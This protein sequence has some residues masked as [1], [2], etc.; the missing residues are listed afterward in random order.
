[1]LKKKSHWGAQ[2]KSLGICFKHHRPQQRCSHIPLLHTE[3]S[4]SV[5]CKEGLSFFCVP[6]QGFHFSMLQ[7]WVFYFPAGLCCTHLLNWSQSQQ[8]SA[9]FWS[10]KN[11]TLCTGLCWGFSKIRFT[12]ALGVAKAFPAV[13]KSTC[14]PALCH[15]PQLGK[16][17]SEVRWG[18]W[19]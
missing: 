15:H 5:W 3:H 4:V 16:Q 17:P 9:W 6:K 7:G 19:Q 8:E 10:Y 1:M 18:K 14:G 2:N 13:C 12:K 11:L